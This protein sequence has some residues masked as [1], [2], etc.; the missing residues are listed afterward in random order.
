MKP[1][2]DTL[3]RTIRQSVQLLARQSD[4]PETLSLLSVIDACANELLMREKPDFFLDHYREGKRL[5]ETGAGRFPSHSCVGLPDLDAHSHPDALDQ[6]IATVTR[7]LEHLVSG[8]AAHRRESTPDALLRQIG[9]WELALYAHRLDDGGGRAG[10]P[11]RIGREEFER[12]LRERCPH[13]RNLALQDFRAIPGGFSK[14]TYRFDTLDDVNGAQQ[15]V[16]RVEPPVKFM[17]LDGMDIANEYPVVL[18]AHRAGLPVAEPMWFEEDRNRLGSRFIVS[19]RVPG[20]VYG[21]VKAMDRVLP[22][23]V[24]RMLAETLARIHTTPLDPDDPL[25][26]RSHLNRWMAYPTLPENTAGLIDYWARQ[27]PAN[28]SDASPLLAEA[29]GWLR[30]NVPPDDLP[31]CLIHGDAGLH[32]ML[33]HEGQLSALLDWENARVGDPSE[34]FAHFFNGVGDKVDRAHFMR[35]YREAGGPDVDE[36]RYRY[37]KVYSCMN[38]SLA[39]LA[40]LARLDRYEQCNVNWSLY[41]LHFAH[42]YLSQLRGAISHAEEARS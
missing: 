15:F 40:T 36:Y 13:W 33:V 12:Y 25:L 28:L 3:L 24:V 5:L 11:D 10:Q 32:N 7:E 39:C 31:F 2:R 9:E 6:G 37:F 1:R 22:E 38:N 17:D 41:G 26:R 23:S 14:F 35:L 27:A 20:E 4:R 19:R 18:Y 21:T 29:I 16:A 30:G 8:M 42:H 34:D